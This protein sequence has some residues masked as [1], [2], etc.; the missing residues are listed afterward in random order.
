MADGSAPRQQV[1]L[2][3]RRVNGLLAARG[4]TGQIR[5]VAF[6]NEE[7]P[8]FMTDLMGSRVY[9]RRCRE[10]GKNQGNDLS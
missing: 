2:G 8:F 10:R 4:R 7:P 6:V 9:A 5:F 3:R 1:E